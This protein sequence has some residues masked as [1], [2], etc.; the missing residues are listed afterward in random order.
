MANGK[1]NDM[2]KP[3]NTISKLGNKITP[4]SQNAGMKISNRIDA[5]PACRNVYMGGDLKK[6]RPSQDRGSKTIDAEV[7]RTAIYLM[8]TSEPALTKAEAIVEAMRVV[9]GVDIR[10]EK[11]PLSSYLAEKI[12]AKSQNIINFLNNVFKKPKS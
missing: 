2:I 7:L 5:K 9:K 12:K 8:N 11:P 4:V 3:I 6:Y 10:L 1:V